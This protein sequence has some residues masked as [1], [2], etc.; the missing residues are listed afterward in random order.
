MQ[1]LLIS[2]LLA[3]VTAC[4][5]ATQPPPGQNNTNTVVVPDPPSGPHLRVTAQRNGADV[6]VTVRAYGVGDVFGLSY[7]LT[8]DPAVLQAQ[9]GPGMQDT[10]LGDAQSAHT[11]L[12]LR[13]GD[14][15]AGGVRKLVGLGAVAIPD[16]HTL[17][18]TRLHAVAAGVTT[19]RVER[20][21]V[22][23]ANGTLVPAVGTSYP[24]EVAP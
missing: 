3:A 17:L 13:S 16:G 24:L 8:F 2:L 22:K 19:L 7:H 4:S 12:A 18:Q 6:D 15:V 21:V 9:A 10:L 20:V 11:V 1:R 14:V 23:R 5:G